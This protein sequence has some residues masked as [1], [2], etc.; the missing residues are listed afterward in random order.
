MISSL[1]KRQSRGPT[2]GAHPGSHREGPRGEGAGGHALQLL[3]DET[4][5]EWMSIQEARRMMD[6]QMKS[7]NYKNGCIRDLSNFQFGN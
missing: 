5:T 4:A 6:D 1:H 3:R 2:A 7:A